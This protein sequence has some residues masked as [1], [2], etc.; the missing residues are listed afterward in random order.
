MRLYFSSEFKNE[1]QEIGNT[2]TLMY[3]SLDD[4]ERKIEFQSLWDNIDKVLNMSIDLSDIGKD[5][6]DPSTITVWYGDLSDYRGSFSSIFRTWR[7]IEPMLEEE[8]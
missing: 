2:V 7:N 5:Y 6:Q 4:N 8:G 3:L 1:I